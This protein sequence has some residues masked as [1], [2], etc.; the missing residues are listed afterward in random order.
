MFSALFY[1]QEGYTPF[2]PD[3]APPSGNG[4]S[5]DKDLRGPSPSETEGFKRMIAELTDR[6]H[7]VA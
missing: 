6:H 4:T 7:N 2:L 1:I 3:P 5:L